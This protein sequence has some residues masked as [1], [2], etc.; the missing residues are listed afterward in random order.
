MTTPINE[1]QPFDI[2]KFQKLLI[3]FFYKQ[4]DTTSLTN[5]TKEIIL[6]ETPLSTDDMK[7]VLNNLVI[8]NDLLKRLYIHHEYIGDSLEAFGLL[9]SGMS[10]TDK[11]YEKLCSKISN[12]RIL[13]ISDVKDMFELVK[14]SDKNQFIADT[15][16]HIIDKKLFKGDYTSKLDKLLNNEFFNPIVS[17]NPYEIIE[18][19]KTIGFFGSG[20]IEEKMKEE[21]DYDTKINIANILCLI[22]S[23]YIDKKLLNK[24]HLEFSELNKSKYFYSDKT[25]NILFNIHNPLELSLVD[26]SDI[27]SIINNFNNKG[28][29]L[30]IINDE[31][32]IKI[33]NDN[34]GDILKDI[35]GQDI[36][37]QSVDN[38]SPIQ[39]SKKLFTKEDFA[40]EPFTLNNILYTISSYDNNFEEKYKKYL[41][42]L[43]QYKKY[44]IVLETY[45]KRLKKYNES[46]KTYQKQQPTKPT[47]P[48]KLTEPIEPLNELF[49]SESDNKFKN[50]K[51][52][53]FIKK[54]KEEKKESGDEDGDDDSLSIENMLSYDYYKQIRDNGDIPIYKIIYR[55]KEKSLLPIPETDPPPEIL[56]KTFYFFPYEGIQLDKITDTRPVKY[57]LKLIDD[58]LDLNYYSIINPVQTTLFDYL[59]L[60]RLMLTT[61][62][63][64][65][66]I[67]GFFKGIFPTLV[68]DDEPKLIFELLSL[69]NEFKKHL[70]KNKEILTIYDISVYDIIE[71]IVKETYIINILFNNFN[72]NFYYIY[73]FCVN[74]NK[75]DKTDGFENNQLELLVF[76]SLKMITK[77]R[78]YPRGIVNCNLIYRVPQNEGILDKLNR[79]YNQ[80]I[81]FNYN[82]YAGGLFNNEIDNLTE[83]NQ[84][85]G[86]LLNKDSFELSFDTL[87]KLKL[88][89]NLKFEEKSSD[90]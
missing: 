17:Q 27:D 57:D 55:Y 70:A 26:W 10:S 49:D 31:N 83:L 20:D 22:Q 59:D 84:I 46:N 37:K 42:T 15:F 35:G 77:S 8:K 45:E 1:I 64:K 14:E 87:Y 29:I 56:K 78:K 79:A 13:T 81:T 76:E 63:F 73:L 18:F 7:V 65:T 67:I 80:F 48:D 11:K 52:Q 38:V 25:S 88:L 44:L 23:I 2:L 68:S 66:L 12:I 62:L 32:E 36:V 3:E 61:E 6:E 72:I 71:I 41:I 24:Y 4:Q 74:Y 51:N 21:A 19:L 34:F 60:F 89:G 33:Q 75:T 90:Y 39:Y 40:K 30:F 9:L 54:Q 53:Y 47:E 58:S 50:I 5:F 69:I 86:K 43:K 82:T 28:G 85:I 16:E